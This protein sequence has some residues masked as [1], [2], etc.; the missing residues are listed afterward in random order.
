ML[1]RVAAALLILPGLFVHPVAWAQSL[2]II[3]L[4]HRTA[5]EVLP[6]LQPLVAS[7]GA[8]SGQD[9]KLFA[10]VSNENLAQLRQALA[11]IDKAQRQ[12]VIAV[13]NSTRQEIE[14]EHTSIAGRLGAGQGSVSVQAAQSDNRRDA[15]GVATVRVL[16]G[17][18]ASIANGQSLPVVTS[19]AVGGG[20]RPYAA[21][22]LD[23]RELS[24]GYLVTPR[25]AGEQVTLQIDQQ[26]QQPTERRGGIATQ[27][28]STQVSGRLGEWI[29]LGGINESSNSTSS[30]PGSRHYETQSGQR[31]L[32]VRVELAD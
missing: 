14:S 21:G 31:S 18:T 1:V 12:L 5:V 17:G 4:H 30:T 3:Q 24:S 8:L 27:S 32:W 6:V 26:S 20:R 25:L 7:G 2:E 28:L 10:R 23:Y 13:R 29:A 19:F 11:A 22:S 9:D 15:A 16:E